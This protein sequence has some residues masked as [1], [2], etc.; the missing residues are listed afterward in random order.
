MRDKHLARIAELM[1]EI[2]GYGDLRSDVTAFLGDGPVNV[3][4]IDNAQRRVRA[5]YELI[6]RLLKGCVSKT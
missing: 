5:K 6:E 4:V 3:D 1:A 2:K